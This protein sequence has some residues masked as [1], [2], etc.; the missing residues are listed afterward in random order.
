M[1]TLYCVALREHGEWN[2]SY[3]ADL[4]RTKAA[5]EVVAATATAEGYN[6]IVC[7]VTPTVVW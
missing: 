1:D 3:S 6:V 4:Y 5:A 7:L 2:L